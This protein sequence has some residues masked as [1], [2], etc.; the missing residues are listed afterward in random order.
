MVPTEELGV[1][2]VLMQLSDSPSTLTYKRLIKKNYL[3]TVDQ[4]PRAPPGMAD[5]LKRLYA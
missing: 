5:T 3:K 1:R 4:T 2:C